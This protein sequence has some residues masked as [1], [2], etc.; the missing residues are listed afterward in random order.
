MENLQII[1]RRLLETYGRGIGDLPLYRIVWS[2]SELEKRYG[3]FIKET[4]AGLYLG[5][6][7]CEREVPK[8]FMWPDYWILEFIQPNVNNREIL[9]RVTY[10]PLW[11]FKDKND[12]PLP[13]DWDILLILIRAHQT[14]VITKSP[15]QLASEEQDRKEQESKVFLDQLKGEASP[16]S[17]KLEKGSREAIVVPNKEFR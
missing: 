5:E 11:V 2:T 17:G 6:E 1:N 4:E 3:T 14:R 8:Y 16:F 15:A 10:E 13:Y 12:K 9:A 7:T